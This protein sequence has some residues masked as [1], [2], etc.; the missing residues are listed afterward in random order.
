MSY[1]KIS[2]ILSRGVENIYPSLEVAKKLLESEPQK[3]Y[4]GIDPTG[5]SLHLGH[6]INLRKLGA[7]QK[8]GHKV[9]LVVGDFTAMIGDPTGK[10]L[11]RK[12]LSSGEIVENSQNYKKQAST[13][14]DFE[15]ENAAQLLSNSDW[16]SSLTMVQILDLA[17]H[18]TV[19]QMLKRDM[20]EERIKHERPIFIH[21]FL[22]PLLQGY[23]SV[24]MEVGGELGGNDQ[25]FNMLVGR[26]LL[27]QIKNKEKIVIAMKLLVDSNGKKMGKTEGNMV[28]LDDEPNEM[29][30]K[31]MSW[32]DEMIVPGF[33]L[34][35]DVSMDEIAKIKTELIKDENNPRDSKEKLAKE[36]VSIY[37]SK[38]AAEKAAAAFSAAFQK[39]GMPE[40]VDTVAVTKGT[41]LSEVLL[42]QEVVKS[43]SDFTR[44]IKEG[45]ITEVSKE[46]KITD[47]DFKLIEN[48]DFKIGK[49]RFLKIEIK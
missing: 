40:D 18:M 1:L 6:A 35:T 42:S 33:E 19:E 22:Y 5:P 39:G 36:I 23:D 11:T 41:T 47:K 8:L 48:G 9:V 32:T 49:K 25:T 17:A 3:F 2:S 15:G 27:K 30:G 24:E 46:L 7:L 28:R 26:Q 14:L 38:N 4:L 45:A 20:F 44:L 13:F 12:P 43:K 34:C 31:V 16:L 21:E 37:Y 29:F 10:D